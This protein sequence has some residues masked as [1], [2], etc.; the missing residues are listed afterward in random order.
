MN[1]R[2]K[3]W[4]QNCKCARMRWG[5]LDHDGL[6]QLKFLTTKYCLSLA[7][8]ELQLLNNSWYVTH[9]GLLGIAQKKKCFGIKTFAV[10]NL[11]DPTDHRWVFR[12]I[13][14]RSPRSAGFVSPRR[15]GREA[16][17]PRSI[18]M[19]TLRTSP[20][21]FAARKCALPKRG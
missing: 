6:L 12:A 19:Q 3:L 11:S 13:V 17:Y 2:L 15:C 9:A 4:R 18:C 5:K 14:Y 20:L 1:K 21:Q 8:G 7:V 10:K 16:T